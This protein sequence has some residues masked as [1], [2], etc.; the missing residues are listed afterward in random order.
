M[1]KFLNTSATNYFLEELIKNASERLENIVQVYKKV[2]HGFEVTGVKNRRGGSPS[3]KIKKP[4][5]F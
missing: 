4:W 3:I 2:G 1:A 5:T